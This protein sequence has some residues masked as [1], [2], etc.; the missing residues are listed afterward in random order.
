MRPPLSPPRR[1]SLISHPRVAVPT[2]RDSDRLIAYMGRRYGVHAALVK[3]V[4]AAES[5]FE[6]GAV[7]RAGAQGMMQLMPATAEELGVEHPFGVVENVD[8]GVRYLRAMLE[9]FGDVRRALAAYN[10]GPGTVDRYGGVPPYPETRTY[11][12]RVLQYYR[13]YRADFEGPAG[14]ALVAREAVSDEVVRARRVK[15]GGR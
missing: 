2:E 9:R 15:P 6:P 7:S 4:I 13:E 3:A 11:V 8:G 5:N 14:R 12:K 10:A 1:R